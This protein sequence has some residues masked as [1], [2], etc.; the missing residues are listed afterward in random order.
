M[1]GRKYANFMRSVDN[2]CK[3]L[4]LAFGKSEEE[5]FLFQEKCEEQDNLF[6]SLIT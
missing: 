3:L 1:S 2:T 6:V 5:G 4:H